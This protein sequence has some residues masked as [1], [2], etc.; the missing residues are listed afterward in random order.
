MNFQKKNQKKKTKNK[1]QIN[2]MQKVKEKK[3][4]F[5]SINYGICSR[6]YIMYNLLKEVCY[7]E[8]L[9]LEFL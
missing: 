8:N 4:C 1:K 5:S 9:S 2:M 7:N 6:F 3:N